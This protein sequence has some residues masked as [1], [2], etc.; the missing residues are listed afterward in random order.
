MS[1]SKCP[2]VNV[3]GGGGGLSCHR[4]EHIYQEGLSLTML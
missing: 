2:G 4:L 3:R 1:G